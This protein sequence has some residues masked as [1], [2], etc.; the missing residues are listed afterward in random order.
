MK[1]HIFRTANWKTRCVAVAAAAV[2]MGGLGRAADAPATEEQ[3]VAVLRGEASPAQKDAACVRLKRVGTAAAVPALA[4]LLADEQLSHSARLALE[5]LPGRAAGQA[6]SEALGQTRGLNK[7]GLL[8]SLGL[9]QETAAVTAVAECLKD[10]DPAVVRSAAQALGRIGDKA[11]QAALQA[12][13]TKAEAAAQPAL[14]DGLLMVANLRLE[15]KNAPGA[16]ALFNQLNLPSQTPAV[17]LAASQGR[18]RA[19]GPEALGWLT[20]GL[21]GTDPVAQMAALA[22]AR[23]LA[24]PA[25]TLTLAG[26]LGKLPPVVQAALVEALRQRGDAAAAPGI[27]ALAGSTDE[28]VRLAV[29]P[30]LGRLGDARAVPVLAEAAAGSAE[31]EVRVARLALLE[32]SRGE[33][34]D[35]M[36]ALLGVAREPVQ[37]ELARALAGRAEKSTVPRLLELARTGTATARKAGF[38]A[39]A[40]MADETTMPALV[41]LLVEAPDGAARAEALDAL[42]TVCQRLQRKGVK[43][44]AAAIVA[45]LGSRNKEAKVALLQVAGGLV[46]SAIRTALRAAVKDRDP[47]LRTAGIRAMADTR[48]AVLLP[49]LLALARG[50]VDGSLRAVALRGYIRLVAEEENT[51]LSAAEKVEALQVALAI[52]Q[53]PEEKRPVLAG[54]ANV[55]DPAALA[56]V[57]TEL[58]GATVTAEAAQAATQ[59]AG[60]LMGAHP[61][62]ARAA[63]EKVTARIPEGPQRQA[64]AALL[65]RLE[66]QS[67]YLTAWQVS[68]PYRAEGKEW[69]ALMDEVFAPE[70]A[71][72][73]TARWQPMPPGPDAQRP[74]IMDLKKALGGEQVVAYARTRVHAEQAVDA[75]L[76]LGS[77]D[78]VKV[79]L[80]GRQV[81]VVNAPRAITPGSD[82]VNVRL[83]A[84]WN[85]LLLKV[86]Q[87]NQGWDYCA[88][89]VK[90]DGTRLTG[91]RSAAEGF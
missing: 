41:R 12:A 82:K 81:Y 35:R 51:G 86:N 91:L 62:A 10:E 88:R 80:N 53:S 23:Q 6:L 64:A 84:G 26:L 37:V 19:G 63:L 42:G 68:G 8:H 4:P 27:Q 33:V 83:E 17:R 72:D 30:A 21:T 44:D 5:S 45:G 20:E 52:C 14:A 28:Q 18:L 39:L 36:V 38:G 55:P 61:A 77:D 73:R 58:E 7:A 79:W 85:T 50:T 47:E 34:T 22:Q 32:L 16:L 87:N 48:D 49:D 70:K 76:E 11:A 31:L 65:G 59:I 69:S 89:L 2:L 40:Q 57:M 78:G 29:Y 9:R 3:C 75:R 90:P 24:Q 71:G 60:V 15:Q 56:L 1:N 54:L 66:A 25:A 67:D 46:D 13:W 74:W 43:P